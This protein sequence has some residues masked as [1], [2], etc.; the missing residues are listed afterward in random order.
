MQMISTT[1]STARDPDL[2]RF[3]CLSNLVMA[4]HLIVDHHSQAGA[5]VN[6]R[7]CLQFVGVL[8]ANL[9]AFV[10]FKCEVEMRYLSK[11]KQR[12]GNHPDFLSGRVPAT[13]NGNIDQ[14]NYL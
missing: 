3:D 6:S 10:F 8:E 4:N 13:L 14:F 7:V 12:P 9:R 1:H 2:I 5:H 11:T